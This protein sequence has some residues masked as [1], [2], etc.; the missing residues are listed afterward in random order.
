MKLMN[1]YTLAYALVKNLYRGNKLMKLNNADL[2]QTKAFINGLWVETA[3]S[4]TVLNPASLTKIAQVSKCGSD[5]CDAAIDAAQAALTPL[6]KMLAKDRSAILRKIAMLMLE[7]KDDLATILTTEQGKNYAEAQG[8]IV[9]SAGFFE[10]FAE[11]AKRIYGDIIPATKPNTKIM[12]TKEAVGV[13]GAITPWNFPLAM[14]ARKFAAAFA[15][16]CPVI[17]KPSEETPLSANALA[18]ICTLAGVPKGCLNIVSGDAVQIGSALMKST[19][20]RKITFTGSTKTG[21][22]LM[23]QAADTVKKVSMELGGNAPFIVFAD[24]DL[25]AA[26]EGALQSKFRNTGQTCVCVNRFFVHDTVYDEFITKFAAKISALKIGDG[27]MPGITQGPLINQMAFDKVAAHVADAK[28]KG[29]TIVC[30]GKPHDLGGLFY[31]PTLFANA[32]TDMLFNREETF[33]PLAACIRFKTTEEVLELANDSET[34]LSAYFYT[35]DLALAFQ[36]AEQLEVGMVGINDGIISNE[37]AP[38]GGIKESGIGREGSKY[39]IE[40][41]LNIKYTL[42]GGL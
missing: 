32:N 22:L 15:A 7:H 18:V 33:G 2:L 36:V 42:I 38:F 13:V 29:A 39:G 40:E 6:K 30:G 4:Y 24:A 23:Q 10:W 20:V 35:R 3:T 14:F 8:E 9:Y 11:E 25:D 27:F 19:K 16:G 5:E 1:I 12:V 41:Y 26:V 34:G 37:V 28:L 21:K 17:W 31:E